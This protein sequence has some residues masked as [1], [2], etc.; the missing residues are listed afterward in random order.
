MPQVPYELTQGLNVGNPGIRE[1]VDV[2]TYPNLQAEQMVDS[3]RQM[4]SSG[5]HLKIMMDQVMLDRAETNAKNHDNIIADEIRVRISDP[6]V[7]FTALSGKSAVDQGESAKAGINKFVKDYVSN[8]VKDPL[9][10]GLVS[11]A[12]NARLQHAYQTM[13]SHSFTQ[14]KVYKEAVF[15]SS[16][17]TK[18]NDIA[19]ATLEHYNNPAKR[20][21]VL[22]TEVT[23]LTN[24][25][26]AEMER[27]FADL[28]IDK[29]NPIYKNAFIQ[30]D[31]KLAQD[32][33]GNW[34][35]QGKTSLARGYLEANAKQIDQTAMNQ[36]TQ[37]VDIATL[38][39]DSMVL[40]NTLPGSFVDKQ[41]RLDSMLKSESISDN[42]W[43]ATSQQLIKMESEFKQRTSESHA[44][45][46]TAVYQMLDDNPGMTI[47]D[48]PASLQQAML[49]V[50]KLTK[51]ANKYIMDGRQFNTDPDIYNTLVTTSPKELAKI[52]DSDFYNKF[53]PKLSNEDY[54]AMFTRRSFG[55][56]AD[57][58]GGTD[59]V[60]TQDQ[61]TRSLRNAGILPTE[62]GQG[63]AKEQQRAY[64]LTVEIE[65]RMQAAE[66]S[67]GAKNGLTESKT[68]EIIDSVLYDDV[69]NKVPVKGAFYGTNYVS[70]STLP[71]QEQRVYRELDRVGLPHTQEN[72]DLVRSKLGIR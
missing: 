12:A 56:G 46:T 40:A 7:G 67:I 28:G 39:K 2:K 60:S 52:S 69:T 70:L 72:V 44:N 65:S 47:T 29:S 59:I 27:H 58:K 19:A 22:S 5:T 15:T 25:R 63:N 49:K 18:T 4:V 51:E 68:R 11:R 34:V 38:S 30:A 3:G 53:R 20:N 64:S 66:R 8:N 21:G 50:P 1:G 31:T 71:P 62:K 41:S 43:R 61:I 6:K 45:I 48:L 37:L 13:D 26:N 55:L 36:M 57:V 16:I 33:V 23:A 14:G 24:A 54:D 9:E 32:I 35:N 10:A 42:M 17:Q